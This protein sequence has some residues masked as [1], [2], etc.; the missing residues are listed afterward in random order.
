MTRQICDLCPREATYVWFER[1]LAGEIDRLRRQNAAL[2]AALER[3]AQFPLI[4]RYGER[5]MRH[6]A[7]RA[8]AHA[9]EDA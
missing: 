5:S 7:E 6:L 4:D 2:L 9:R 3:I 1:G 8:I